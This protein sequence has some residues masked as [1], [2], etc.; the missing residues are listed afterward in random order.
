MIV[1]VLV[2]RFAPKTVTIMKWLFRRDVNC[3]SWWAVNIERIIV[4]GNQRERWNF[5]HDNGFCVFGWGKR[6]GLRQPQRRLSGL[7]G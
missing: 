6:T 4:T 5:G 3:D 7:R 2:R 1:T